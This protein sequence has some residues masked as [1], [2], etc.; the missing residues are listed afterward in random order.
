ML[1]V[2]FY[3]TSRV[4]AFHY[5]S[6]RRVPLDTPLTADCDGSSQPEGRRREGELNSPEVPNRMA[7]AA[8]L[9][10]YRG[11]CPNSAGSGDISCNPSAQRS[12]LL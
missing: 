9:T 6:S 10:K 11:N 2:R 7:I 8:L 5:A 1:K 12:E 3:A 4:T